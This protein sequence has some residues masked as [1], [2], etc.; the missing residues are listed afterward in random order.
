MTIVMWVIGTVLVQSLI[1]VFI[2]R[3]IHAGQVKHAIATGSRPIE[4][5]RTVSAASP[6][7]AAISS[8]ADLEAL[9]IALSPQPEEA[10]AKT[11]DASLA[12]VE[13]KQPGPWPGSPQ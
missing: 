12:T 5:P 8:Y 3:F 1:A 4:T 13:S 6:A 2:G 10:L 11:E 7:H 9:L